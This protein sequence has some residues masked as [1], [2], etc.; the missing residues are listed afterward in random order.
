[1]PKRLL[2]RREPEGDVNPTPHA[3]PVN[4]QW[5]ATAR[6][7]WYWVDFLAGWWGRY[8][9][10]LVRGRSVVVERG[11]LDLCVDPLR[12]RL[13]GVRLPSLLGRALPP[14]DLLVV[15]A[16]PAPVANAR[17]PE[18]AVAEIERQYAAWATISWGYRQRL[19]VDASAPPQEAVRLVET[20]LA[21]RSP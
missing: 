16:V 5:R 11:W 4:A 19:T 3:F 8:R 13:P 7:V 1:M 10:D 2:G 6:T 20:A 21:Q 18:L 9:W 12:Y 17:K 15:C 14:A